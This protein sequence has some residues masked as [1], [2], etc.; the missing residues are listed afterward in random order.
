[1]S[2]PVISPVNNLLILDRLMSSSRDYQSDIYFYFLNGECVYGFKQ[3]LV[4]DR[5]LQTWMSMA[6]CK[7]SRSCIETRKRFSV[8]RCRR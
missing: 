5:K 8:L 6:V 1:M 4:A 3:M 2:I 7:R